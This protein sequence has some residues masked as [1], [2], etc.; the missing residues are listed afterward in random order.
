MCRVLPRLTGSVKRVQ[1]SSLF[2]WFMGRHMNKILL[3]FPR[4][5][6]A[7]SALERNPLTRSAMTL[8]PEGSGKASCSSL[9]LFA[10]VPGSVRADL[11]RL[12]TREAPGTNLS[13]S[14]PRPARTRPLKSS[15][16]LLLDGRGSEEDM[17]ARQQPASKLAFE[18]ALAITG[19]GGSQPD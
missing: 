17:A 14:T 10:V 8:E 9:R 1:P 12:Q 3:V 2:E 18:L 15:Q 19:A 4:S 7:I 5:A 16:I 11:A 13:S 6:Q